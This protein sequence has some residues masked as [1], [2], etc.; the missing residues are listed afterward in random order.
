MKR[1]RGFAAAVAVA[2]LALPAAAGVEERLLSIVPADAATVGMIRL[3]DVRR[4]PLGSRLFDD[5]NAAGTDG[6]LSRFLEEAGLRPREDVDALIFATTPRGLTGDGDFLVAAVGRFDTEKLAQALVSRGASVR[7]SGS[8]TYYLAEEEEGEA[9]AIWFAA[10]DLT[11]AGTEEAVLRAMNDLRTGGTKFTQ[12]S[13]LAHD[14]RRVDPLATGWLIV[15]VQRSARLIDAKPEVPED[16]PFNAAAV[17]SSMKQVSTFAAWA[18]EDADDILFGATAVSNDA[19]TR[20]L[21]ADVLRGVTAAWRMAAQEKKP[22][23]VSVIRGFEVSTTGDAVVLNGSIPS[24]LV[25]KATAHRA[26]R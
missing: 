20:D 15:D 9:P 11:V 2:L 24:E 1:T 10:R 13:P 21:L 16:A 6:E 26:S 25:R 17:L 18:R 3:D 19:E 7:T 14:L 22:E 4:S 12:A 5:I 8:A 23:L